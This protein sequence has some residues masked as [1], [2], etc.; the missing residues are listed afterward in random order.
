M[1][2]KLSQN[3]SNG[4]GRLNTLILTIAVVLKELEKSIESIARY[5]LETM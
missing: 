3:L 2:I 5:V 1:K 4:A